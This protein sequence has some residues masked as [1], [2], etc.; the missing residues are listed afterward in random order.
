M[1]VHFSLY[2]DAVRF[3]AA[4][5]VI[6]DHAASEPFSK[7]VFWP[8][9]GHYGAAAVTIFFVLSGYVIAYVSSSRENTARAYAIARTSRLYSVVLLALPLTFICDSI[10]L[11]ANPQFYSLQKVLWKPESFAGYLSAFFFVNEWQIFDFH[12]ISPGTNGPYW[13]LSFEATY[14]ALAAIALFSRRMIW[15]LSIPLIL[16]LAGRTIA[17]MLPIWLCGF[18]L[19]RSRILAPRPT[20]AACLFV[21]SLAFIIAAPQMGWRFDNGGIFFPWGRGPFNRN[22]LLDYLIAAA[23]A[24]N[25]I[26]AREILVFSTPIKA[27][28]VST[29]RWLGSLTFPLYCLHYPLLC[30]FSAVNPL[31]R[32]TI[33]AAAFS[34]TAIFLCVAMVTPATDRLRTA[35]RDPAWVRSSCRRGKC[36]A[37]GRDEAAERGT[38]IQRSSGSPSHRRT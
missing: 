16:A 12:G 7:G 24:L 20:L 17:A 31:D 32:T 1:S 19:Y 37:L 33:Q 10:G 2:L 8:P 22:L 15:L 26:A 9:L 27:C 36:A 4:L 6:I 29:I 35:M 34:I 21:A 5:A 28:A 30:L 38:I 13:S 25:L 23:F 14:Y 18:M 3:L 11:A